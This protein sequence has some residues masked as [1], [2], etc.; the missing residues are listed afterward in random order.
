VRATVAGAFEDRTFP[1]D[2]NVVMTP[3]Q[4]VTINANM[5]AYSTAVGPSSFL[6]KL[7]AA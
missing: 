4:I 1:F 3:M 5:I 7:M 2:P 6:R